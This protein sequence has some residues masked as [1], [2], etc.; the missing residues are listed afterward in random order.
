VATGLLVIFL[1]APSMA[2]TATFDG[3]RI[4]ISHEPCSSQVN[5]I[6][7]DVA[8]SEVLQALAFELQF[9]LHFKSDHDRAISVELR[10]PARE[11][12]ETLGQDDNIMITNEVDVRC[13]APVDRLMAVWFLGT[14]PEVVYQPATV[15]AAYKLPETGEAQT[16]TARKSDD[17]KKAE[18][19]S[20]QQRKR[21][22]QMTPEERYLYEIN[23]QNQKL[24]GTE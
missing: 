23:R 10:K 12:I 22:G 16:R 15:T 9:E 3:D 17:D 19:K 18:K 24:Y 13:E 6:A 1:A 4:K 11:L 20:K 5:L 2:K 14:G 8:L 7:R 21:R